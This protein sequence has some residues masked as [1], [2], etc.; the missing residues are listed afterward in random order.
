M[1]NS[2]KRRR[3]SSRR[4]LAPEGRQSVARGVSPWYRFDTHSTG[5]PRTRGLRPWLPTAAPPGLNPIGASSNGEKAAS[6]RHDRVRVHG[7][8]PLERVQAGRSVLPLEPP[9]RAQGRVRPRR[10]QD[11]GVRR[12]VGLRVHRDRLAEAG[13]AAGHRR[14][15][16]LHAQQHAQGDRARRGGQ[17][18]GDPVREAAGDEHRGGPRDGRGGGGG[19]RAEHGV[20]QLPPHP[21]GHAR[22]EAHRRGPARPHLPLPRQVPPGLD[23]Q[24]RPPARRARAVA[25]RRGRGRQRRERRPARPLHRHVAL[26]ERPPG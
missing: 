9:S 22:Q 3:K 23:H 11:Q 18:E 7:P 17:Q 10:R 14:D 2:A 19:R 12:P 20:V 5:S 6:R 8:R 4:I 1:T 25:A 21:R 24:G 16:H 13:R 26:A 15:R